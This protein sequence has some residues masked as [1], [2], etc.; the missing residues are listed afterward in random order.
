MLGNEIASLKEKLARAE[1]RHT[2]DAERV[3]IPKDWTS[4]VK[5]DTDG[6]T[7]IVY[8]KPGSFPEV[9]IGCNTRIALTEALKGTLPVGY[10][11]P[12]SCK[13]CVF[14]FRAETQ[15]PCCRCYRIPG[16]PHFTK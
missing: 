2:L 16:K 10:G 6:Y 15:E 14:R 12:P 9:L 4:E 1:I 7:E 3:E 8:R 13:D 11:G 5:V